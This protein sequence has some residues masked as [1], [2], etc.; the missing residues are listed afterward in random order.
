MNYVHDFL[1]RFY[2]AD[3]SNRWWHYGLT[4]FFVLT[5]IKPIKPKAW[6][7]F[8]ATLGVM[9]VVL[10]GKYVMDTNAPV[11]IEKSESGKAAANARANHGFKSRFH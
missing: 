5:F 11:D 2:G 4:F 9:A 3:C 8:W 1:L 7:G 6:I 10:G